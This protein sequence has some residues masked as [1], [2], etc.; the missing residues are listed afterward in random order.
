MLINHCRHCVGWWWCARCSCFLPAA[1]EDFGQSCSK[2]IWSPWSQQHVFILASWVHWPRYESDIPWFIWYF[3]NIL[4]TLLWHTRLSIWSIGSVCPSHPHFSLK[5]FV[6]K[7]HRFEE[8]AFFGREWVARRTGI[9]WWVDK[10]GPSWR[11]I[12]SI[13]E[14]ARG[15]WMP[16]QLGHSEYSKELNWGVAMDNWALHLTCGVECWFQQIEGVAR[17]NGPSCIVAAYICAPQ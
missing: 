10:A 2:K 15:S 6:Y 8:W 11:P 7:S 1:N 17:G 3:T 4:K 14:I 5:V 9:Y 12:K 13:E 16:H